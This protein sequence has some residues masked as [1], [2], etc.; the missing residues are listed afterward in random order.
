MTGKSMFHILLF[1][2]RG[3]QVFASIVAPQVTLG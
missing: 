1:S 3:P 2:A